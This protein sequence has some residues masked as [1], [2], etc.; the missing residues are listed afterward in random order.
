LISSFTSLKTTLALKAIAK[1]APTSMVN[2]VL[3]EGKANDPVV[4]PPGSFPD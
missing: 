3:L 2:W 1:S 4:P